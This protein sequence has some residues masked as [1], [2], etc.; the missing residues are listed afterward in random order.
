MQNEQL[1]RQFIF[2]LCEKFDLR[3]TEVVGVLNQAYEILN[4]K[5]LDY[6]QPVQPQ[7]IP[8][9][10]EPVVEEITE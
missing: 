7:V 5:S 9:Q 4:A 3:P 8:P 6:K 10:S 2:Y 1:E